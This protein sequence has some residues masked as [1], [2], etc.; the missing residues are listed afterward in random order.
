[1]A[2]KSSSAQLE[3]IY[4]HERYHILNHHGWKIDLLQII[5]PPLLGANS[6]LPY[7]FPKF[8]EYE[9]DRF[10]LKHTNR[11][12][13]ISALDQV[14]SLQQSSESRDSGGYNRITLR[15]LSKFDIPYMYKTNKTLLFDV[16]HFGSQ[17]MF[18][19]ERK[20]QILNTTGDDEQ[21]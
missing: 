4:H 8:S 7:F 13:L 10:A 15:F 18:L 2:D 20:Y 17:S 3:A 6:M 5:G 1:V 19:D 11:E 14:K 16:V 9:A 12:S 21:D